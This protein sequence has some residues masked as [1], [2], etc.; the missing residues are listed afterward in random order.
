MRFYVK[1]KFIPELIW[2]NSTSPLASV[3]LATQEL[4]V[5]LK[6][7]PNRVSVFVHLDHATVLPELALSCTNPETPFFSSI[8]IEYL[9]QNK[10]YF[11]FSTS[12]IIN[13]V[14]QNENR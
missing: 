2:V 12:E 5:F 10:I 3:V 11:L 8:M 6:I 13:T 14:T 7:V 4:G 1:L 9:E